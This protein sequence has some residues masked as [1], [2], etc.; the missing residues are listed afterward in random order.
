LGDPWQ[1]AG[2]G[3]SLRIQAW[4]LARA[5]PG[6]RE[7]GR[8]DALFSV[9]ERRKPRA[10]REFL[11]LRQEAV[12]LISDPSLD[13]VLI[14]LPVPHPPAIYDAPSGEL[15]TDPATGYGDSLILADRTLGELRRALEDAGL[16]DRTVLLVT[17]DHPFRKAFWKEKLPVELRG[18]DE[19]E[20]PR[21]PFLLKLP[22]EEGGFRH[23]AK[24]TT[25]VSAELLLALLRGELQRSGDVTAW[26]NGRRK[27]Q[28]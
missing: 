12:R 19:D 27:P 15:S 5:A 9:W 2:F 16:A 10:V 13:L 8:A 24:F 14:H 7:S 11:D 28:P 25:T 21:I 1:E 4:L 3:E 18:L 20:D 22:E 23:E 17:S 26:L 6:L